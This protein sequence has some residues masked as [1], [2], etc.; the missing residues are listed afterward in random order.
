MPLVPSKDL[1]QAAFEGKYAIG[2]FNAFNLEMV[3]AIVEA[4]EE[5]RSPLILQ[6]SQGAIKYAG[7]EQATE[8]VKVAAQLASVP[9]VLHLDHGTDF[10]Q[11]VRCLRA[12]FTSL[13]YDGSAKPFDE[14]VAVTRHIVEMGHAV[15]VS[16]EA[17]LGRIG[18]VEDHLNVSELEATMTDPKEARRFVELTGVDSLA[19][20]VGTVHQMTTRTAQINFERISALREAAGIPLVLHG[21]SGVPDEGVREAVARGICKI[22]IATHLNKAFVEAVGQALAANPGV[23]DPRKILVR[24]KEAVKEGVREKIRLFGSN[25]RA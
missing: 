8:M 10:A 14:N 9:V 21:A 23:V 6:I 15:G 1:L 7:L 20:A 18:G 11:V 3:Q 16:V 22:N 24:G 17:E 5:E 25:G 2:A 12:G 4:A 13:M 19:V